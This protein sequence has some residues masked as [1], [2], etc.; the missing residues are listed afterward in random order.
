MPAVVGFVTFGMTKSGLPASASYYVFVKLW[1]E[2]GTQTSRVHRE[3]TLD[4]EL[5]EGCGGVFRC[6][7]VTSAKMG[8]SPREEY[9]RMNRA[10]DAARLNTEGARAFPLEQ[11]RADHGC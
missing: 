3:R 2:H 5:S 10:A 7:Y 9:D 1:L 11:H 6:C 8:I 4:A